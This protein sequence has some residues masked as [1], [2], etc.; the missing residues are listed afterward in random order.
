MQVKL[1][2]RVVEEMTSLSKVFRA[3]QA[4]VN[5]KPVRKI[6]LRPLYE[7]KE[8]EISP[9]VEND[10]YERSLKQREEAL[11]QKAQQL[12]QQEE[13]IANSVEQAQQEIEQLKNDWAQERE[14]LQEQAYKE[15]YDYGVD[16]GHLDALEQMQGAIQLANEITLQSKENSE[17]YLASQ[18]RVILELSVQMAEKIIGNEL[19]ATAETYLSIVRR[20]IKE[21]QETD[22]IKLYIAPKYFELVSSNRDELETL[23]PPDVTFLIF[24]NEDFADEECYIE[25]NHGRIDVTIDTQLNELKKQLVDILESG[26]EE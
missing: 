21:A 19:K 11:N 7:E 17:K 8:E 1:L 10:A 25:T 20:A 13:A 5:E 23:F 16:E 18:E 3:Y 15:G 9:E 14:K 12:R 22:E 26:D 2:S 6:P 4:E 24:A